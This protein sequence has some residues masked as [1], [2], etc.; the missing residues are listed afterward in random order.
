MEIERKW[1]LKRVPATPADAKYFV[2]QFYLS[3]DPE[4]RLRRAVPNGDYPSKAPYRIAIKGNGTLSRE[5]IQCE[6]SEDFYNRARDFVNLQTIEKHYLE[7]NVNGSEVGV[8]VVLT[9][10]GFIYAE[11]EFETEEEAMA[12]QFPWPDIV[13]KEITDDLSYKMK[14]V[15]RRIYMPIV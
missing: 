2:E 7:Y 12:Y 1:L 4:V 3:L 15:W 10:P 6:V 14:N 8:A 13:E 5:E 11:V 9:N